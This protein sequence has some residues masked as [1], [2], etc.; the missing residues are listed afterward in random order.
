MNWLEKAER[1]EK[2]WLKKAKDAGVEEKS[3]WISRL[4]KNLRDRF[5]GEA[6]GKNPDF[7]QIMKVFYGPFIE[8]AFVTPNPIFQLIKK[9]ESYDTKIKRAAIFNTRP[10]D[11]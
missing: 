3:K 2:I 9:T 11:L 8:R 10:D 6:L 4:R 7:N 1:D 5:R